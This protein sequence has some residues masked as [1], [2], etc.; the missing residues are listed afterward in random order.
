MLK[1][2]KVFDSKNQIKKKSEKVHLF[3]MLIKKV[4]YDSRK[5]RYLTFLKIYS[6]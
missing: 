3:S 1:V 6:C 5:G 2:M 4:K